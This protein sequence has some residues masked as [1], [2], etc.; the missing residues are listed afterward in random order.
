M[1][2]PHVAYHADSQQARLAVRLGLRCAAMRQG[3]VYALP[4]WGVPYHADSRILCRLSQWAWLEGAGCVWAARRARPAGSI[5]A[6]LP[7]ICR[8]L[9]GLRPAAA[10]F[11]RHRCSGVLIA[12]VQRG[13]G[14]I[15]QGRP[16]PQ[17]PGRW[18]AAWPPARGVQPTLCMLCALCSWRWRCRRCGRAGRSW[19]TPQPAPSA[20]H[21]RMG[22]WRGQQGRRAAAPIPSQSMIWTQVGAGGQAWGGAWGAASSRDCLWCMGGACD[23]GGEGWPWVPRLEGGRPG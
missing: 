6:G 4:A 19:K 5:L 3:A 14:C 9:V 22:G 7:A 13:G 10:G 21:P 1:R 11:W 15:H 17:R 12:K 8:G 16:S 2:Y 20:P 23:L 18:S